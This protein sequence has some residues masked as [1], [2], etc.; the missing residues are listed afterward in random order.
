[1]EVPIS[2]YSSASLTHKNFAEMFRDVKKT[3]VFSAFFFF[4]LDINKN[5]SLFFYIKQSN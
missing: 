4:V 2:R 1:M 3:V 5:F